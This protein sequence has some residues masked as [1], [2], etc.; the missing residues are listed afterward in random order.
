[1]DALIFQYWKYAASHPS[2]CTSSQKVFMR[3]VPLPPSFTKRSLWYF[4]IVSVS[5]GFD[6]TVTLFS[7]LG[8]S[9]IPLVSVLLRWHLYEQE[10]LMCSREKSVNMLN[11]SSDAL[12]DSITR[13]F[14]CLRSPFVCS[15][16]CRSTSTCSWVV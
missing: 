14:S 6:G 12:T 4:D 3:V 9:S 13:R 7:I 5:V 15:S 8:R 11:T 10:P 2:S 1:M 16:C